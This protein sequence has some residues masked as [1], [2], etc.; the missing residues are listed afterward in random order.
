MLL[1]FVQFHF[2]FVPFISPSSRFYSN[3]PTN[4]N[5]IIH[6]FNNK[7][8]T[9]KILLSNRKYTK[10]NC[11]SFVWISFV[12]LYLYYSNSISQFFS[13]ECVRVCIFYL[14]RKK[15]WKQK[16][17]KKNQSQSVSFLFSSVEF[18]Q[19]VKYDIIIFFLF[20]IHSLCTSYIN[21]NFWFCFDEKVT[22]KFSD[23]P[24]VYFPSSIFLLFNC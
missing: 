19:W 12:Y 14:N 16:Y 4:T 23:V 20:I 9:H 15:K 7:N 24:L 21:I 3:S 13:W 22:G 11:V 18:D 5:T 10:K 17:W 1:R 6:A 8:S 2:H